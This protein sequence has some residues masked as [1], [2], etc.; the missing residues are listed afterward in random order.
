MDARSALFQLPG[1]SGTGR[2]AAALLALA[3]GPALAQELPSRKPGLWEVTMQVTNAPSQTMRQC[4]DEKTDLQMQRFGQ[5]LSEQQCTKNITRR[6][7]DRYIGESECKIGSSVAISRSVL[8]GDFGKAYKGEVET[9]YAPPVGGISASKV[10]ILAKW[11]GGCPAGWKPGDMEMP[12][13]GRVNVGEMMSS[14]PTKPP[15]K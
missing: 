1:R 5:G 6:D 10:T 9:R 7:G 3:A 14:T 13:M 12:G 11:T 15:K 8:G 2:L 4:I